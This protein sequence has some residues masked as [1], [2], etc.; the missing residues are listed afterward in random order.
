MTGNWR[1]AGFLA[2]CLVPSASDAVAQ[3]RD[4]KNEP[5][6]KHP[7]RTS[8]LPGEETLE[9]F[10]PAKPLT[11]DEAKKLEATKQLAVGFMQ[12]DR[13]QL[14]KAMQ[15]FRKA[16][17]NDPNSVAALRNAAELCF[18]FE[19]NDEGMDYCR[20]ALGIDPNDHKLL[21]IY[22]VRS[23]ERGDTETAIDALERAG[24]AKVQ[25]PEDGQRLLDCNTELAR[26]YDT[27][28]DFLGM[29][30]ALTKVVEILK[31]P[32]Q[33]K[34]AHEREL[35]ARQKIRYYELLGNA[36]RGA[37]SHRQA[38]EILE[39]GRK[40][41]AANGRRMSFLL[42]ENYYAVGDYE[43]ALQLIEEYLSLQFQNEKAFQLYDDVLA[44]LNRQDELLAKLGKLADRDRKNPILRIFYAKKL[45]DAKQ[46]AE[47]EQQLSEVSDRP[48]AITLLADVYRQMNDPA[49]LLE[50]IS[51]GLKSGNRE[52]FTYTKVFSQDREFLKAVA[53]AARAKIQDHDA[54]LSSLAKYIL[55]R[56]A[57]EAKEVELGREFYGYCIEDQPENPDIRAE[58][59]R[60]LFGNDRFE[61]AVVESK[62]AIDKFAGNFELHD[63]SARSLE[64]TGKT[65]DGVAVMTKLIEQTGDAQVLP[66]AHL[67][68]AWIYQH[69]EQWDKAIEACQRVL[70]EFGGFTKV[71]YAQYQLANVYTMKGDF[72]KAE[73]TLLKLTD[74]DPDVID[75]RIYAAANNDLGYVW[76]DEGKN[77]DRAEKMIR[78][79]L[80][81]SPDSAAYLDSMGWVLF[82]RKNYAEAIVHL[83]KAT[84]QED[85]QD[86]VIWDHLGD[87]YL[88]LGDKTEAKSAWKKSIELYD[89]VNRKRD[90][91]KLEQVKQK[92]ELLDKPSSEPPVKARPG[93]P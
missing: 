22:G 12:L 10:V 57:M 64:M 53:K 39:E 91:D 59:I 60:Q 8:L 63:L 62:K 72:Q 4:P 25:T 27:K 44:K 56:S 40:A 20:R 74:A 30:R 58:L 93:G 23:A 16:L 78:I 49:K 46:Y 13:K 43:K 76:A 55:A 41:D 52:I 38:I 82:K 50:T 31:Q 6:K 85:G 90:A 45:M 68:I 32:E 19:R 9:L 69:A 18:K 3:Y 75:R 54:P 70:D 65:N 28:K 17:E 11:V 47:A 35:L 79:A 5:E 36:L 26:L 7:F 24:K 61:E 1:A 77:L 86:P 37:G 80:E 92:L 29:A 34:L 67:T 84:E 87:S 81:T 71:P 73:E 21:Y 48:E 14:F 2:L 89:K 83:K 15:A 42:A 33:F 51:K 88:Q 66:A